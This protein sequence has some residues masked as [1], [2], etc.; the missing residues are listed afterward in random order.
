[1]QS[2]SSVDID[3]D[4]RTQD[5]LQAFRCRVRPV[6]PT[7]RKQRDRAAKRD[8]VVDALVTP[9]ATRMHAQHRGFGL[10]MIEGPFQWRFDI[11]NFALRPRSHRLRRREHEVKTR[12]T[13][14][15]E[16]AN[17][18]D[19]TLKH[20]KEDPNQSVSAAQVRDRGL[21]N[22]IAN[23]CKE[24][25][26]LQDF[27]ERHGSALTQFAG[28]DRRQVFTGKPTRIGSSQSIAT[29][30]LFGK[31]G[32]VELLQITERLLGGKIELVRRTEH[33]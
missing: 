27:L 31:F 10:E 30:G 28:K 13:D 14:F 26:T 22:S 11:T 17:V 6:P 20:R 2:V 9:I 4:V 25:K 16:Q 15:V 32:R 19:I 7:T 29:G 5:V 24:F 8:R 33:G 12:G 3:R 23:A 1:M 21:A 18:F